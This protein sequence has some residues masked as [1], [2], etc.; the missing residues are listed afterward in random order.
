MWVRGHSRSLNL[1]PFE[2]FGA[3]AYS[4][5][6]YGCKYVTVIDVQLTQ[7]LKCKHVFGYTMSSLT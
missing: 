3:V 6:G 1:V 7:R 4:P 5:T 2:S